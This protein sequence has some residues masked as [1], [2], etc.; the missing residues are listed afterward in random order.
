MW[1]YKLAGNG[2]ET[3]CSTGVCKQFLRTDFDW[4]VLFFFW[5]EMFSSLHI[6]LPFLFGWFDGK[7][8]YKTQTQV[9]FSVKPSR[10]PCLGPCPF[11]DC[12]ALSS[13]TICTIL[14]SHSKPSQSLPLTHSLGCEL[15]DGTDYV[16]PSLYIIVPGCF[17]YYTSAASSLNV[18]GNSALGVKPQADLQGR[19]RIPQ[20]L[21]IQSSLLSS[22][23]FLQTDLILFSQQPTT[24]HPPTQT[25]L[26]RIIMNGE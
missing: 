7:T 20:Y 5:Q 24:K 3:F 6:P 26:L 16:F 22:E 18:N 21:I 4:I 2:S 12:G 23:L 9:I 10:L 11:L 13:L 19:V 15:L 25:V 8:F 1:D 14:Q 17:T